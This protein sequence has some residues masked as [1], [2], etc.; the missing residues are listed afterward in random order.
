MSSSSPGGAGRSRS[1]PAR[2]PSLLLVVLIVVVLLGGG[3]WVWR[4][5]HHDPTSNQ[6]AGAA[7]E[8]QPESCSGVRIPLCR[9][10]AAPSGG[11]VRYAVIPASAGSAA[12]RSQAV[13]VDLGGP[14][15]AL[16]GVQ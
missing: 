8:P 10:I 7:A 14:G 3:A 6:R 16:F 9:R 1:G 11:P 15:L 5:A 12:S 13:L 2:R 4:P